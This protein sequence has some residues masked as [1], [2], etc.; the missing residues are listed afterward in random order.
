MIIFNFQFRNYDNKKK[1]YVKW[2]GKCVLHI[3]QERL[4]YLE[5]I[6]E[7]NLCNRNFTCLE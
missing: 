7:Y 6:H 2:N 1:N 4:K 3:V 5:V